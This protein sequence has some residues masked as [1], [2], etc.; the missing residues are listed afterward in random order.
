MKMLTQVHA[1]R[2]RHASVTEASATIGPD[3]FRCRGEQDAAGA[4]PFG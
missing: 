2:S 1:L 4:I 3:L